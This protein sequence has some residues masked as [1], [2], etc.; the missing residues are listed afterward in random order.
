M[1]EQYSVL[2]FV[3]VLALLVQGCN[4]PTRYEGPR[5]PQQGGW[6]PEEQPGEE[7]RP[8]EHPEGEFRPE[9]QPPEE[10]PEEFWTEERPPEE[11]PPEQQPE[12]EPPPAEQPG[13]GE[14]RA[15]I[16][17][18][19]YIDSNMNNR[20]DPGESS[21]AA[22]SIMPVYEGPCPSPE[23]VASA[24]INNEGYYRIENLFPGTYCVGALK[25][26]TLGPG[27]QLEVSFPAPP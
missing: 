2:V 5:E 11:S 10:H 3:T 1:K 22:G 6:Q 9:E 25:T 8:E 18:W 21:P 14:T 16:F 27:Q 4:M 20:H 7:F 13:G 12:G 23:E 26:V 19:D 24:Q 15:V 17:G